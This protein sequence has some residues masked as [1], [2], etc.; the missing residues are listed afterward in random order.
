MA[1]Q[2]SEPVA[3]ALRNHQSE[4]SD[5]KYATLATELHRWVEIFDFEFKLNLPSYPVLQ[6]ARLR[7]A[8]ATYA[9]FRGDIGTKDN[10]TFN[11]H[12]LSRDPALILRTLCHE[13]IHLWQH[14]QGTP[15]NSNYHNVEYRNKAYACGLIVDPWGCTTGHTQNFTNVL[16]KYGFHLEPL[17]IEM[18]LYGAGKR[19]QKMKKWRCQCTTV[20]CATKLDAVCVTCRQPFQLVS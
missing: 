18:R 10:I 2:R 7:N 9:W 15:G 4:L 5:W 16:A 19:E 1:F 8:Y 6:F 17:A 11:T 3:Q 14:Y 12:E 13:L 20:R